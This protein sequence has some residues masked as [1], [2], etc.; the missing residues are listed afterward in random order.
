MTTNAFIFSWDMN[1]VEA[2]VPISQFE[3]WDTTQAFEKLA[4]N[5]VKQNPVGELI[6]RL[7]LRARYN[8]QR[9]YE[10]YAIDC[11]ESI[12]EEV[13]IKMWEENPQMC[14]DLIRAK[15]IKIYSDR[16]DPAT[17]RIV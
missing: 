11:D 15:G 8:S 6:S 14:A 3:D 10:I 2:I 1:G 16:K 4:G 9:C 5:K 13:W 12:T 17:V 7:T